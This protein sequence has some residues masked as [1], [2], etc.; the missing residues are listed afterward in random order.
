ME[1]AST[2]TPAASSPR[3]I[4]LV[5]KFSL[6][7]LLV[8][9]VPMAIVAWLVT[10]AGRNELQRSAEQNLQLLAS[11]TAA[12]VDQ[13]LLDTSRVA[14]LAA[15]DDSV[16]ALCSRPLPAT[17]PT[18]RGTAGA[19]TENGV[20][21]STARASSSTDAAFDA[22]M[23]R[24]HSIT[25]T[26]SDF[27]SAIVIDRAAFGIA[28][29]NARNIGQ[30]L[31]FRSYA[32]EALAGRP[33]SELL[34]GKTTSA[35][36]VYFSAPVRA[37]PTT[38]GSPVIGAVVIKLDAAS[39]W[40]IV[41]APRLGANGYAMLVDRHGIVL[42]HHDRGKLYQ[43]L[44]PLD[45]GEQKRIDPKKSFDI[46]R[47]DSLDARGLMKAMTDDSISG[48]ANFSMVD[49][50]AGG[51]AAPWVAGY[52]RMT[53]KPWKV[54]MVE[55]LAQLHAAT[56]TIVARTLGVAGGVSL[57][58]LGLAIWRAK[59]LVRPIVELSR[60]AW[61]LAAGDFSARAKQVSNDEIGQLAHV[62]NDMVPKL[63]ENVE[64]Q[65]SLALAT[66]VQQALLPNNPPELPGLDVFGKSR[67]CDS[68]G[69]DYYDFV[70]LVDLPDQR[71]ALIAV[72]DVTG[73]GIGA[74]L[75]MCTARAALRTAAMST[76]GDL[77]A[78]L[79][80]VNALL[81]QEAEHG[82]FMTLTIMLVDPEKGVIRYAC[83]GH[84]PIYCF[85]PST[86]GW[87]EHQDGFLA[88]GAMPDSQYEEYRAEGL[89][90]GTLI[91]LGTDGIWEARN[92]ADEMY[93]KE[94]MFDVLARNAGKPAPRW[95]LR[96]K[97]T[98]TRTWATV[99]R[100]TTSLT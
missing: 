9:L 42:S 91:F 83:A 17:R 79:S 50:G 2:D 76:G 81:C 22:V 31:S 41:E 38:P 61:T 37:D 46:D 93:G 34:V 29:T 58:A 20:G 74:A 82:L 12:R 28:S 80:R 32:T 5:V 14:Q 3:G 6:D 16:I 96:W 30:D 53:V 18:A 65:R 59:N 10:S 75:L 11:V 25:A 52:Q 99:K 51:S 48:E 62:F 4:P 54:A 13:L 40:Q 69:G 43:S 98:S 26:N 27:A 66:G 73:H 86:G 88:L 1:P 90:A 84:D 24:L 72:G 100:R 57:V 23:R 71:G 85:D 36:G 94:R 47:F 49:G 64:L 44:E 70:D 33:A 92:A 35:P 77:G 15:Q 8:A 56:S 78:M 19:S 89:K 63:R 55:P 87:R 60:A 39:I 68:T 97:P 21:P 45:E 67:Y 7:L 95:V